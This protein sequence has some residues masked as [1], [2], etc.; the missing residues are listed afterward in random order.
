MA[1]DTTTRPALRQRVAKYL[2]EF[3]GRASKG[4]RE[5]DVVTDEEVK[6]ASFILNDAVRAVKDLSKRRYALVAWLPGDVVSKA[7][8]MGLKITDEQAEEFLVDNANQIQNDTVERGFDSIETLLGMTDLDEIIDEFASLT[9]DE[10]VARMGWSAGT[11]LLL[12][13]RYIRE[14]R[15]KE[16]PFVEWIRALAREEAESERGD[17]EEDE[18]TDPEDDDGWEQEVEEGPKA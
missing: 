10:I 9:Q 4:M 8:E 12:S 6:E 13:Q 11:M 3:L 2:A 18:D 5:D 1:E 17:D 15:H 16:G 14:D 7:E